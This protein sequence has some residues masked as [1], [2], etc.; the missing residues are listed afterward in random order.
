MRTFV[1]YDRNV[2]VIRYVPFQKQR[3]DIEL[4]RHKD[5]TGSIPD[6]PK[7]GASGPDIW[8]RYRFPP[9]DPYPNGFESVMYGRVLGGDIRTEIQDGQSVAHVTSS[10]PVTVLVALDTTRD[11]GVPLTRAQNDVNDAQRVGLAA[12]I[13]EHRNAWHA[14]WRRSFVQIPNAYLNR[15][16]FLSSYHLASAAR[17]GKIMPGLDGNWSWEDDPVWFAAYYWNTCT[18]NLFYG[19]YSGNHLELT[20]PYND[21]VFDLLPAARKEAREVF[22]MRG[23]KFPHTSYPHSKSNPTRLLLPYDWQMCETPWAVQPLWWYYLYSQDK[24]FLRRQ[25]YPLLREVSMFFVD[26]LERARDGKFDLYPTFPPEMRGLYPA[27]KYNRNCIADLSLIKYVLKAA[28]AASKILD[29]DT[30]MRDGWKDI[31]DNLRAYPTVEAPQGTVFVDVEGAPYPYDTYNLPIPTMAIFPGEDIG[32]HSPPAVRATALRTFRALHEHPPE[33]GYIMLPMAGVRLG[34]DALSELETN[35]RIRSFL[36]GAVFTDNHRWIW[37]ENFGAPI[38]INDSIIQ[39]YT[40]Q[41]RLAPV[42]IKGGVRFGTL[43]AVGAFL[44]SGELR[45]DGEVRYLTIA[46]EAGLPCSLVKPWAGTVRVRLFPSMRAVVVKELEGSL[47]FETEKGSVYVV[48][49][50][51]APWEDEPISTVS[52]APA[53]ARLPEWYR[54]QVPGRWNQI[55][56][57]AGRFTPVRDGA[58]MYSQGSAGATAGWQLPTAPVDTSR[59]N[60]LRLEMSGIGNG[61]IR[62]EAIGANGG[63]VI[64]RQEW[65]FPE[66]EATLRLDLPA[67]HTI[68]AVSLLTSTNDGGPVE[69]R[70]RSMQFT[71]TD[72]AVVS[73]DLS[74]MTP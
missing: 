43:R 52:A 55:Q 12:L 2:I 48:D 28:V 34:I 74:R 39:S 18:E 41:L 67:S 37:A 20:V 22:G 73:L 14:F 21:T 44:V 5:T 57:G 69:S 65:P 32:L 58:V 6:G 38:V 51:D 42:K 66:H 23:A 26:Y 53:V 31:A 59:Y 27:F 35:T 50:P 29:C 13:Q 11:S 71:A 24:D 36:N 56:F 33:Q 17:A 54:I 9:S 61:K 47:I 19:T 1:S 70:I 63:E 25:G 72:G 62:V 46:S 60:T 8:L 40:G 15:Q 30:S 4:A 49:R 3:F 16:W 45:P 7:F 10:Q 68:V 64:A